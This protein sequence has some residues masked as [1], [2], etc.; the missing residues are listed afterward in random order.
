[1][2][3]GPY[4][5]PLIAGNRVFHSRCRRK[6]ASLD[7]K[8]GKELWTQM[9][10]ADH[11][12]TKLMYG[13]A[14]SPMAFREQVIVPV[15]GKGKATMAFSQ[16]DGKAVWAKGY[17]P[18]TYSSPLL[19][20]VDGLEQLVEVMDG[21]VFGLNPINGDLQWQVAFQAGYG[22]SVATPVWC[23]GQPRCSSQPNTMPAQDDP[24]PAQRYADRRGRAGVPTGCACTTATPCL[25]TARSIS[26]AAAK[27][28]R[29]F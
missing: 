28:A 21:L 15:G 7:K 14:S 8:T 19:I 9:L 29:P 11:G 1:M 16:A 6:V 13:Y 2:G 22:I 23:P 18:N 26:P 12:G 20:N 27:A 4:A 3:N 5:T 17:V 10:W 24:S 25:W